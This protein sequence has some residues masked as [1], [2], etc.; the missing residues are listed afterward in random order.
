MSLKTKALSFYIRE[1]NSFS[2]EEGGATMKKKYGLGG[3]LLDCFLTV[4]TGGLWLVYLL[5]KYLR[6]NTK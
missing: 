4:I 6:S 1:K 3:F 5:I 2:Y